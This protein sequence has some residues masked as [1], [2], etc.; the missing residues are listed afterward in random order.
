MKE[1]VLF[2]YQ[3]SKRLIKIGLITSL[4][5]HCLALLTLYKH[6][7]LLNSPF[8][9]FFKKGYS[10]PVSFGKDPLTE[11]QKNAS[12]EEALNFMVVAPA[13]SKQENTFLEELKVDPREENIA[14]QDLTPA[15]TTPLLM[16]EKLPLATTPKHHPIETAQDFES[17]GL[18]YSESKVEVPYELEEGS[19]VNFV[20]TLSIKSA[21]ENKAD[22]SLNTLLAES[23]LAASV[24]TEKETPG[25]ALQ[26]AAGEIGV[27]SQVKAPSIMEEI[28]ASHKKGVIPALIL[29]SPQSLVVHTQIKREKTTPH[30]LNYYALPEA[31]LG[32]SWSNL[33]NVDLHVIPDLA[34]KRYVFFLALEPTK[35]LAQ[36]K[37]TQN[38][39]F[40]IDRSTSIEK[41]LFSG[42]KKA[43]IRALSSLEE[44]NKFN[45]YLFDQKIVKF[46]E[47][48]VLFTKNS[49]EEAIH[50]LEEQ[51]KGKSIVS[52]DFCNNLQYILPT[53][54][55]NDEIHTAIL[56][57]DG[58]S[59]LKPNKQQKSIGSWLEK[60]QGKVAVYTAAVGSG[61]NLTLL[62]LLSSLNKG[63]LLHS[64]TIASFPRKLAKLVLDLRAPLATDIKITSISSDK[65]TQIHFY[66][67]SSKRPH[68]YSTTPYMI[69]G[70]MDEPKD[71]NIL[72]QAQH[73]EESINI[74][75]TI[76]FANA[77]KAT[78][79][80]QNLWANVHAQKCFELF[81]EKGDISYIQK[82]EKY[83]NSQANR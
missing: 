52:N 46:R 38:F 31:P 35:E 74:E 62:E 61:N 2:P 12:L 51:E 55:S 7:F 3:K 43:V 10:H 80:H 58:N 47:N 64:D 49:L 73:G 6:P 45:I 83:L 34:H 57:S 22:D 65:D 42:Y 21:F 14:L 37:L 19:L 79:Q 54:V 71:F 24:E 40:V 50:F 11:M 39:C 77:K 68:I 72:I 41:H 15:A 16:D 69:M 76:S 32:M 33:F 78:T 20:D 26:I 1:D 9:F 53:S 63:K 59:F 60:N 82:A 36:H 56:L 27:N 44:G 66:P 81:L 13:S 8:K 70:T 23:Q 18:V 17:Q 67:S 28:I 5:I 4:C 48:D 25:E 75:K 29:P 30:N